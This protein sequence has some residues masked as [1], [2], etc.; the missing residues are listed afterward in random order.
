MVAGAKT[1]V[2]LVKASRSFSPPVQLRLLNITFELR[3]FVELERAIANSR[4][5]SCTT[6]AATG[7]SEHTPS[8]CS[9]GFYLTKNSSRYLACALTCQIW[10]SGFPMSRLGVAADNF[11]FGQI[12]ELLLPYLRPTMIAHLPPVTALHG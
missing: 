10:R 12:R 2:N 6:P 7:P 1:T 8:W 3:L 4:I 9:T 5:L 11:G